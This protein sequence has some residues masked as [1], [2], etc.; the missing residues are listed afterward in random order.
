MDPSSVLLILMLVIFY[1]RNSNSS[2]M[3]SRTTAMKHSAKYFPSHLEKEIMKVSKSV[4]GYDQDMVDECDLHRNASKKVLHSEYIRYLANLEKFA[5]ATRKFNAG[6]KDLR[7]LSK[8]KR[9][10][11]CQKMDKVLQKSF[12]TKRDCS[13][14]NAGYVEPLLPPMRHPRLCDAEKRELYKL[15]IEYLVHDFGTICRRLER[16]TRTSFFDLGASLQVHGNI[17]PALSLI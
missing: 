8:G 6:V 3:S 10:K 1:L 2:A 4:L 16:D 12:H 13:W 5:D 7:L 11:L 9:N 15:N 17:N 14:T